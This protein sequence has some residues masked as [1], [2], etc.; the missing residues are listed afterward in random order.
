MGNI[1]SM[2]KPNRGKGPILDIIEKIFVVGCAPK[3]IANSI[4]SPYLNTAEE[5]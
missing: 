1:L 4:R 2:Q 5:Y 3:G